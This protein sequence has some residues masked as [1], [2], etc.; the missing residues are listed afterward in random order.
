MKIKS[1]MQYM[2]EKKIGVYMKTKILLSGV[3]LLALIISACGSAMPIY[4]VPTSSAPTASSPAATAPTAVVPVT[5]ST[6]AAGSNGSASVDIRQD[7]SL[8]SILVDSKGMT[9]Y[10]Y[11][12]DA[13]NVSNCTGSCA[14]I[15]PPLLTDGKPAAGNGVNPA[16]LGTIQRSD[17]G[18]QVTFNG[19]PLYTF[20]GDKTSGDVTGQGVES[21]FVI[22]PAG[23]MIT[24]ASGASGSGSG[25]GSSGPAPT[26]PAPA[27]PG[28]GPGYGPSSLNSPGSGSSGSNS[29]GSDYGSGGW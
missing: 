29:Q 4:S 20:E 5:G 14:G 19:M 2:H 21:F 17:G 15:W 28:Y 8:G 1:D 23:M 18:T 11:T 26:A 27:V 7:T 12:Q 13:M 25:S 24:T 22:N 6:P 3:A 9:L 16:M 10:V